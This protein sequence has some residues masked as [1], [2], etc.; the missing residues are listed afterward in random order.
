MTE[1]LPVLDARYASQP[2][3]DATAA[4]KMSLLRPFKAKM[5]LRNSAPV[6]ILCLGDSTVE[7]ARCTN[8]QTRWQ[9]RLR[10]MLRSRLGQSVA[11]GFGYVP[12]WY[13]TGDQQ[14]PSPSQFSST[15][16][17]TGSG[18]S[19]GTYGFGRRCLAMNPGDVSTLTIPVT[20]PYKST[21]AD[22]M[23][24]K[25]STSATS[26]VIKLDG[27]QVYT[28]ATNS[29]SP[30]GA[31]T[32][33]VAIPQDGAQHV[34]TVEATGQVLYFEGWFLYNGD[35]SSGIRVIDGAASGAPSSWFSYTSASSGGNQNFM[36]DNVLWATP[37]L[38][39]LMVGINDFYNST[40]QLAT[41]AQYLANLQTAISNIRAK[42][43]GQVPPI[44]I[45]RQYERGPT[46]STASLP[47]QWAAYSAA[48]DQL[49]AA[50]PSLLLY[51]F[52]ARMPPGVQTSAL[53]L[54]NAIDL[55]HL[56]DTGGGYLAD[57]FVSFLVG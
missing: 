18:Q 25:A 19:R 54:I 5:A 29:G 11:G 8:A 39:T 53:G 42:L 13:S 50:D 23:W 4:I 37:A 12:A 16:S 43:V 28:A 36:L 15:I 30:A 45:M 27:T 51:D 46:G 24:A 6:N 47:Y 31:Q 44:I 22:V 14:T 1:L 2:F 21:S 33:R 32:Y 49:I 34:I 40:A 38:I 57:D 9:G 52:Q 56:T 26:I 35:E 17:H 3:V 20:G 55:T 7:G 10:D 41:P 48:I